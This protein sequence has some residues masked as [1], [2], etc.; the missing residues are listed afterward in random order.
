VEK[1]FNLTPFDMQL[2]DLQ[3]LFYRVRTGSEIQN[4]AQV[5]LD[6]QQLLRDVDL[7]GVTDS[8][9]D[10]EPEFVNTMVAVV[11]KLIVDC[12]SVRVSHGTVFPQRGQMESIRGVP[13]KVQIPVSSSPGLRV[14]AESTVNPETKRWTAEEIIA[15]KIQEEEDEAARLAQ[16]ETNPITQRPVGYFGFEFDQED[17]DD[18]EI[19]I[20]T[21]YEDDC[22]DDCPPQA[23]YDEVER[24]LR[25]VFDEDQVEVGAAESLHIVYTKDRKADYSLIRKAFTN[26]GWSIFS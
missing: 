19:Q 24:I 12:A 4:P 21:G 1:L 13:Q 5:L 6:V 7:D 26:A 3:E 20:Y 11:G 8:I 9:A 23:I 16:Y 18:S 25:S 17:P 15:E 14:V 22:A 10:L 2:I